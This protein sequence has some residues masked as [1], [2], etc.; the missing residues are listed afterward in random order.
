[1][2]QVIDVILSNPA[3]EDQTPLTTAPELGNTTTTTEK[4]RSRH[5]IARVFQHGG[6]NF[7]TCEGQH[8][9]HEN[10][11]VA[12]TIDPEDKR[13]ILDLEAKQQA[14]EINTATAAGEIVDIDV[15]NLVSGLRGSPS[16][17]EE[18]AFQKRYQI[19]MGETGRNNEDEYDD[20]LDGVGPGIAIMT[21]EEQDEEI[22]GEVQSW[23]RNKVKGGKWENESQTAG[24][25]TF[26]C[27][28]LSLKNLSWLFCMAS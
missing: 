1:M 27:L 13:M 12:A 8:V 28:V 24:T 17:D 10:V 11:E 19:L 2:F 21:G 14:E 3:C 26:F 7:D 18:I 9:V 16:D 23:V 4:L 20:T 5:P 22:E 6:L 25:R 15:E